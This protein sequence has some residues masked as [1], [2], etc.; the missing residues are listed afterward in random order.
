MGGGASNEAVRR[1]ARHNPDSVWGIARRDRYSA[2]QSAAEGFLAFLTLNEEGS[3]R[4]MANQLD[5]TDPPLAL[6]TRQH[7]KPTAIYVWGAYA[8]GLI[9]GGIPLAFEKIW[10][11]LY[12]DAPLLA[13]AATVEGSR[14]LEDLGFRRGAKFRGKEAPLL[15]MSASLPA[16]RSRSSHI[17][18]A[19][20]FYGGQLDPS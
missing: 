4:L 2:G 1:V 12:R 19:K 14:M 9:A 20:S 8:P 5:A 18:M 6:V 10:T 3:D 13:R 15:K 11:R 7:E 16:F 17:A